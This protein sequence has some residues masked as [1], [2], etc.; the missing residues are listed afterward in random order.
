MSHHQL[1]DEKQ[2]EQPGK[3]DEAAFAFPARD[4]NMNL[5]ELITKAKGTNEENS[6]VVCHSVTSDLASPRVN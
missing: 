2:P 3:G 5:A 6:C 4:P 1:D